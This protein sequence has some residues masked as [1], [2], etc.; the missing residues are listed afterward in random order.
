MN[1]HTRGV[2]VCWA[3]LCYTAKSY[4][5]FHTVLSC[6]LE[7]LVFLDLVTETRVLLLAAEAC[8]KSQMFRGLYLRWERKMIFH[9][10]QSGDNRQ[11][12]ILI[13]KVIRQGIKNS[14]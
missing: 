13:F 7:A 14:V 10:C 11:C 3:K 5:F 2:C 6:E 12:G 1:I 8:N 9:V 4:S